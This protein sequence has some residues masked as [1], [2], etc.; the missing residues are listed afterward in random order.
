MRTFEAAS[1]LSCAPPRN[2]EEAQYN[3][4]FPIAATLIDGELGPR[5]VLPPRLFVPEILALASRVHVIAEP[6]F[7]KE[8]PEQA[9]AEVEVVTCDGRS[10]ASG[11]MQAPWQPPDTQPTD[12]DLQNKF[13]RLAAPMI[14]AARVE[15]AAEM[16]W[17]LDDVRRLI[18]ECVVT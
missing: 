12:A 16:I 9:L 5:Q 15:N 8:F 6:R 7:E 4:A 13:H 1:R 2:T 10:F 14:G 3:L 11:V 17:N 18:D